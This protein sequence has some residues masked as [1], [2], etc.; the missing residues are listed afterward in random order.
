[1]TKAGIGYGAARRSRPEP[2]LKVSYQHFTV[3]SGAPQGSLF[4]P[5]FLFLCVQLN[6]IYLQALSIHGSCSDGVR[7]SMRKRVNQGLS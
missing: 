2:K 6:E 1:M 5:S 3:A 7:E 4:D